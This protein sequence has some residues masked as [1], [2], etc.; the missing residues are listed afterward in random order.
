MDP[1]VILHGLVAGCLY[2]LDHV[3]GCDALVGKISFTPE[4]HTG[5]GPEE[6]AMGTLISVKRQQAQGL[7]RERA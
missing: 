6:L 1:S 5:L 3:K 7:F 2:A 4:N